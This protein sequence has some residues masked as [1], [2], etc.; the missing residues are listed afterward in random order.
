MH[1]GDFGSTDCLSLE[2]RAEEAVEFLAVRLKLLI[3]LAGEMKPVLW[4][5]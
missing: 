3:L 4:V 1:A 2:S 5:S